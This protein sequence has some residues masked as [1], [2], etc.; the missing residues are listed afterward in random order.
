MSNKHIGNIGTIL[1]SASFFKNCS[2]QK[3]DLSLN[4]ISDDGAITISEY[5]K[6]NT[7]LK[8]LNISNNKISNHGRI[9]IA[10]AIKVNTTLS[11]LNVSVNNLS[12]STEVAIALSDL[13]KYNNTLEALGISWSDSDQNTTYVYNVGNNNE[14]YVNNAWPWTICSTT[15]NID[16]WQQSYQYCN[17]TDD[18]LNNPQ[19]GGKL[20]FSNIEGIIL[21]SLVHGTRTIKIA[22]NEIADNAAV[23]ISDFLKTNKTLHELEISHNTIS[24][25]AFK[26]IMKAIQTN[27]I[28]QI[29]DISHNE[30]SDDGAVAIGECLKGSSNALQQLYM[31]H[32]QISNVG[33]INIDKALQINTT[34]QILDISHNNISDD[35]A[36]A[37]GENLRNRYARNEK[38]TQ[39]YTLQ[40]LN[41]SYNNIS[42]KGIIAFS[43]CLESSNAV[44]TLT[45]SW[46]SKKISV[47]LNINGVI[48]FC[49]MSRGT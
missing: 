24:S 14:C 31:S 12:R 28:M 7:I 1:I 34:I 25:E 13:L 23:F 33:I 35:G 27:T 46:V 9:K 8:E 44:R 16:N 3:L 49:N 17:G 36:V 40:K 32:N 18:H 21:T 26:Q 29:L 37:M 41:M 6:V 47:I 45:I 38:S 39:D 2:I 22:W 11:L 20:Q 5:L 19:L 43:K 48:E 15:D 30:V 10:E 42:S 4:D